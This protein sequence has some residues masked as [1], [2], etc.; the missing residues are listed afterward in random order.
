MI[1]IYCAIVL[2]MLVLSAC[3]SGTE[4]AFNMV[5]TMHLR[6]EAEEGKSSSAKLAY[7]ISENFTNTLCTILIGNNLVNIAASS[8]ATLIFM[9]LFRNVNGGDAIASVVSTFVL[10]IIVLIFAEIVPKIAAKSHAIFITKLMAW[11]MQIL[12]YIL[13]P[14]VFI[15]TAGINLLSKLWGKDSDGSP[16]I[17]EDELSSLIDTVEKEGVIDEDQSDLLQST[18]D[19]PDTTVEDIM[20]HRIDL[21]T[22]DLDDDYDEIIA[23]IEAATYSRLPVYRDSIDDIVGILYLNQYYKEAVDKKEIDIEKML[24]EPCYMHKTLKLPAALKQL[25]EKQIHMAIVIDEF[26][27]TLG[28]VTLEDILEELVGDIWDESDEIVSEIVE[29]APNEY[30][31][32]GET[33]LN[34][35]FYELDYHPKDFEC[36]YSTVGGWAIESLNSEP[37]VG[38]SFSYEF[39]DIVVTEM[40]D[41]IRVT[42]LKVTV[43]ERTSEGDEEE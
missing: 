28:V 38:D 37:H 34:D 22:I 19:F 41:D 27:G 9:E 33:S 14:I 13:F 11:P 40:E 26:G 21:E 12:T 35:F 18:L 5:N 3:F 32:L 1:T 25:R 42:K 39:L 30:E 20:T 36:E 31:I 2:I 24:M 15:V 6:R 7:K 23:A 43:G 10:T 8:C 17:T 29:K 16:E 4:S